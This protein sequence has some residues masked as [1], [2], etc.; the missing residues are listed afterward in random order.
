MRSNPLKSIFF[1]LLFITIS[2]AVVGFLNKGSLDVA[3]NPVK[4][5]TPDTYNE[6]IKQS[7]KFDDIIEITGTPDLLHQVSQEPLND[8][9]EGAKRN[10]YYYVGLKEYGFDF[11]VRVRRGRVNSKTQTFTG[12]VTG[13][14]RTE[15]GTRIK[16]SL[17]K[18]VNFED[19]VN[20]EI[21]NELDEESK[22][23][24]EDKS[25]AKFTDSTFLVLDG[26]VISLNEVYS[27]IILH[28]TLLSLFLITI[29]RKTVFPG[30]SKR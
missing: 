21:A 6:S 29:F 28:S 23:Q 1:I 13:L 15:F 8:K 16:N 17:N 11:V 18:P 27:N 3:N 19:S 14:S 22:K 30:L 25:S 24:I 10:V 2:V 5:I 26:E 20:R 7:I 4:K 9:D 12:R